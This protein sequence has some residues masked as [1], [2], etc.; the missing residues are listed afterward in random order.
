MRKHQ[1][2][3]GAK[4]ALEAPPTSQLTRLAW[5][6]Y[7]PLVAEGGRDNGIPAQTPWSRCGCNCT[8]SSYMQH[9]CKM[10]TCAGA[11]AMY[12]H[13]IHVA[14]V[15]T[16]HVHACHLQYVLIMCAIAMPCVCLRNYTIGL[17]FPSLL[18]CLLPALES[19]LYRTHLRNDKVFLDVH[20]VLNTTNPAE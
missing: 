19:A 5:K 20:E 16:A 4:T 8:S 3:V 15:Q 6:T 2:V 17:W 9:P 12:M 14:H 18:L 1:K 11:Y 7:L 13:S 10:H